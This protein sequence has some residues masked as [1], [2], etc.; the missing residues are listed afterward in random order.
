[1]IQLTFKKEKTQSAIKTKEVIATFIKA[2]KEMDV[3]TIESLLDDNVDIKNDK[4][5]NNESKWEFLSDLKRKFDLYKTG[6]AQGMELS[7][8][9]CMNCF[10]GCDIYVFREIKYQGEIALYFDVQEGELKNIQ[11]C[12]NHSIT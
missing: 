11:M 9:K 4:V 8:E 3:L 6:G 7:M 10:A 12:R 2:C 5:I 1:M